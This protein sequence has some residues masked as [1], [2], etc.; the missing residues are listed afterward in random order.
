MG[1]LVL[2]D[3]H[4]FEAK[5][6]GRINMGLGSHFMGTYINCQPK[7]THLRMGYFRGKAY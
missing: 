5:R 7:P 3:C 4:G 6:E 2:L 1:F